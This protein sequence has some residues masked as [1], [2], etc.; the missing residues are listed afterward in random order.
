[1]NKK[2]NTENL[3][4]SSDQCRAKATVPLYYDARGEKLGIAL[5]DLNECIAEK[6][7][8]LEI[9]DINVTERLET[10]LRRDYHIITAEKRLNQ[11][12][13]DFV[14]HYSNGWE[15][16]TAMMVCSSHCN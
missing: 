8:G 11:I 10:A 5:G 15:S 3:R 16:G 7:E 1:M 9:D 4:K 2:I 6:L 13:R 14:L 12:A